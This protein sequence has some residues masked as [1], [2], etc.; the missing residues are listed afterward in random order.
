MKRNEN[1]K[2]LLH[3]GF[4][5]KDKTGDKQTR[6]NITIQDIT[7][8]A[9]I[10]VGRGGAQLQI[11]QRAVSR[12]A[13]FFEGQSVNHPQFDDLLAEVQNSDLSAAHKQEVSRNLDLVRREVER[14]E[15]GDVRLVRETLAGISQ[16]LPQLREPLWQWLEESDSL[17]TPIK[18]IARQ[19]LT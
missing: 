5:G 19:L 11:D 4:I 17:S 10:V 2:P 12:N 14:G 15:A 1:G 18:I 16:T 6:G 7:S 8:D 13:E 3:W 9:S